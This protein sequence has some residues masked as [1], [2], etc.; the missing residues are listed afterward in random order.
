MMKSLF[1]HIGK[2]WN[3][4]NWISIA[5]HLARQCQLSAG[6]ASRSLVLRSTKQCYQVFSNEK[7]DDDQTFNVWFSV[8]MDQTQFIWIL[9]FLS[10]IWRRRSCH[11]ISWKATLTKIFIG[12]HIILHQGS[13]QIR[14]GD[15]KACKHNVWSNIYA[16]F[17][18]VFS[19]MQHIL[20]SFG[21]LQSSFG[22]EKLC[23]GTVQIFIS[24]S[25]ILGR[26]EDCSL[27]IKICPSGK[28]K[29]FRIQEANF[30]K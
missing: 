11:C 3:I 2:S 12:M 23:T 25:G 29:T 24:H 10:V 19:G 7:F 9:D 26:I 30:W 1:C 27:V 16:F 15:V 18:A 6:W 28:I 21:G 20:P 17:L 4:R 13:P 5:L 22:A 8:E 14:S